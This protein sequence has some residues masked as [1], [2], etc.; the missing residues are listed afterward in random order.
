MALDGEVEIFRGHAAAIVDDANEAPAAQFDRDV[1]A[2]SA[3]IERILDELLD[4][5]GRPLDDLARRDAIDK[6]GIKTT[7][8]HGRGHQGGTSE[9]HT[10][11]ASDW[12]MRRVEFQESHS[13]GEINAETAVARLIRNFPANRG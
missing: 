8:G 6:N 4:G 7:D 5:R 2:A 10:Q 9:F 12:M 11:I 13:K 3:R 1:D